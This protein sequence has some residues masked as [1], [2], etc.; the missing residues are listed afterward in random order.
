MRLFTMKCGTFPT[1]WE[2]PFD[3]SLHFNFSN[4]VQTE[5]SIDQTNLLA[6]SIAARS[7]AS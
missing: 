1:F 7:R 3:R 4:L 5:T 2:L 6:R